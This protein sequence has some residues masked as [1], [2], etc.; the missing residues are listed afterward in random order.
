MRGNMAK[1]HFIQQGKGGVGKSMIAAILYQVL[2]HFGKEV[3]AYDTDPVNATLT[4]FKEFSVTR[5]HILKQD[6]IDVRAFD[7]LLEGIF[8]LP[9]DT[10]VIVDNGASS[11]VALGGYLKENEVIQLLE[12]SGHRVFLHTVIT[13]GQAI[14]DTIAGLK[15][16]ISGFPKTPIVIWLNHYFGEIQMDGKPFE[17]FNI[18]K[19]YSHQFH[20]LISIPQGNQ[21][22]IGKDL[23]QLFAKRQS[24]MTAINSSQGIA[25]RSRLMRYWNELVAAVDAAQLTV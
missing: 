3:V 19:E 12:E 10:H 11:F 20:A 22:T 9:E 8:E 23:E 17:T 25:V 7:D 6:N 24:F 4:G 18:Y 5:L 13:G 15:L 21:A 1:I 16:L 2:R 14:L